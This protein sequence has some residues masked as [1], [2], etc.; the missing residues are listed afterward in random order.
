VTTPTHGDEPIEVEVRVR[1]VRRRRSELPPVPMPA[2]P[3]VRNWIIYA[4]ISTGITALMLDGYLWHRPRSPELPDLSEADDVRSN[5]SPS[6][7]SLRLV[8]SWDLTLSDSAGKPDSI[9]VRVISDLPKDTILAMQPATELADT[10]YL[11]APEPGKALAGRSCVAARHP[12]TPLTETCT[13]WQYVKPIATP[14]AASPGVEPNQIVVQP[15]GL[16]VDP[17]VG[18]RCARWQRTHPRHSVWHTVNKAAVAECTGPNGKPTVAQFCAFA[19]L[20][21]GRRVKSANSAN[22]RYCDELFVEW[23][24]DRYS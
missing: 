11:P 3:N 20:P 21:D 12:G 23:T 1:S 9:Q 8:V 5:I 18:G 19:V 16:Q 4:A 2:G 14:M 10:A 17:D 22:N 15:N 7:D 6:N 13:P 24:R